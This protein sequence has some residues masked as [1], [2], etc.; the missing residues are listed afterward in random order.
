MF[1]AKLAWTNLKKNR[2]AYFPFILATVFTVVL[3][4]I[5]QV[6][7][8]NKGMDHL[9]Q[10]A[11]V[12]AMFGLGNYIIVIF[13]VIFTFYTH[14]FLIKR[15]KKELGLYNILG[16]DK[17]NL[18]IMLGYENLFVYLISIV[19]GL[20]LGVIF[21]KFMFLF[22]KKLISSGNEFQFEMQASSV[23]QTALFFLAIFVLL[24][25]YDAWQVRKTKPIELL[26]S[27]HS[28]EKE[29]R[30][31]W[32]ITLAGLA[33]LGAGYAISLS[34]ESPIAAI[35]YF[36]VAV[37]LVIIGTYLLFIAGSVTILK[38]LKRNKR[39]YYQPKHFISISGM[40]YRMKQNG[41]GLATI[42][43]LSTMA[44]VTLS[45]TLC[46]FFGTADVVKFRNPFGL[47]IETTLAADQVLPVVE[48][49]A[50]ASDIKLTEPLT[51]EQSPALVMQKIQGTSYEVTE[52]KNVAEE[53]LDNYYYVD[54]MPLAVYN[55]A[56]KKQ[57][58]LQN[59]QLLIYSFKDDYQEANISLKGQRFEVVDAI[60]TLRANP[61][62]QDLG[63]KGYMIVAANEQ[64]IAEIYQHL[65]PDALVDSQV[66]YETTIMFD[67]DGTTKNQ[68]LFTAAVRNDLGQIAQEQ[69]KMMVNSRAEDQIESQATLGGFLFIGV[70]FGVSFI[71]AT[72]LIIY[73]KQVSEGSDDRGR[74]EIMQ[75]VGLS[76]KEVK[77]TIHSQILL[78]FF[79]PILV[80]TLHLTFAFPI[81]RKLLV[82]FGLINTNLLIA[83]TVGTVLFFAV[84][85]FVIYWQTSKVYY[86]L[87]ER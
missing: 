54:F 25:L 27:E 2:T 87:V 55:A 22:F 43:I 40:I 85:Y 59:D 47:S 39:F 20:G 67:L 33:S 24:F 73:Y 9:P 81:I 72:A 84:A 45:T 65:A 30:S 13:S 83:T 17:N 38:R 49:A 29:P 5:M 62:K 57:V 63:L 28:G 82:L 58:T 60:K 71:L 74:F 31:R 56:E 69:D 64:V 8:H 53:M 19:L 18:T 52:P 12:K 66:P 4:V 68:E 6:M 76:H 78:V 48:A 61:E 35:T 14:S 46:L 3:N 50:M 80:A 11:S 36:F 32:I 15:R 1:Y 34:I 86:R 7:L 42:A 70:I 79:L 21:A 10:A 77:Q 41:A 16:L 75:Q 26:S 23:F 44:L 37:V 51:M